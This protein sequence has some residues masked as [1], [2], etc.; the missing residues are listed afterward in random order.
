M[1]WGDGIK[2]QKL[3]IKGKC[4]IAHLRK[5]H[6]T[7]MKME[8]SQS[9]PLFALCDRIG[10]KRPRKGG[11]KNF[12]RSHRAFYAQDIIIFYLHDCLRCK[13]KQWRLRSYGGPR[14]YFCAI[15]HVG[16]MAIE[17]HTIAWKVLAK[18]DRTW[19]SWQATWK[20]KELPWSHDSKIEA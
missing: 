19:W 16:K 5:T 10:R 2:C 8:E 6:C 14:F 4:T 1:N 3:S 15:A 13:Q 12:M 18:C 7:S 9:A 17:C 11:Q 20:E